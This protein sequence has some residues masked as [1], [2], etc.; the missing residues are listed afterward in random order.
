VEGGK[1]I[2]RSENL[3]CL[4]ILQ[5]YNKYVT[6]LAP[7]EEV[8]NIVKTKAAKTSHQLSARKKK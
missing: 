7:V 4:E 2:F 6:P 3:T 1:V 8:T 5:S